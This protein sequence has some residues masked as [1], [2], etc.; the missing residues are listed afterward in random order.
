[1][2]LIS[3]LNQSAEGG[4]GRRERAKLAHKYRQDFPGDGQ[5]YKQALSAFL[6]N[7]RASVLGKLNLRL[8][9]SGF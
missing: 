9:L 3:G 6:Q 7:E 8:L 5:L 1:M 4:L 2:H